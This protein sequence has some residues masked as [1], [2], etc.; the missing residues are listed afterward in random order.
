MP[1]AEEDVQ[2]L[3]RALGH[4]D[5]DFTVYE[6]KQIQA[7]A[8]EA[9]LQSM[10]IRTPDELEHELLRAALDALEG[11]KGVQTELTAIMQ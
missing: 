10:P 1:V 9:M 4:K 7:D 8:N 6:H 5:P 2:A 3:L 11:N